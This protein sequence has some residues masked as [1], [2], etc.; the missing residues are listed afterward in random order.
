L[1]VATAR[2]VGPGGSETY[3]LT[4]AEHLARLGHD[5][6][7]YAR[8]VGEPVAGWAH[9]RALSITAEESELPESIDAVIIG[10]YPALALRMADRYPGAA[11]LF[12][13]HSEDD[14]YL[15]P[16]LPG[17]VTA[18]VALSDRQ[19]ERAAACVGAGEVVRLRQPVDLRVFGSRR[20]SAERPVRVLLLGHY[21]SSA[22]GR[23]A[24]IRDAWADAGLEW[25][26]IGG[27]TA[28]LSVAE[29]MADV[30]IVVGYGRA[31]L[32]GMACGRAVYVHDHSG[33]EGWVTA[34]SYPTLE[35][36]GFAVSSHRTGHD[37]RAMRED[38]RAYSPELGQ[39]GHE[40]ARA[41]HDARI[42]AARLVALIERLRPPATP[43]PAPVDGSVARAL[44]M[45]AEAHMRAE[46]LADQSR[47][48]V[49][50]WIQA[51]AVLRDAMAEERANWAAERAVL[52]SLA[53]EADARLAAFKATRRYRLMAAVMRP[54]DRRRG[55]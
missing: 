6:V 12:V 26:E 44:I 13:P 53:G 21:H 22:N 17:A 35:A 40:L 8:A 48:E 45:L 49:K 42:H 24:A 38:L 47:Q 16:P 31:A 11:R 10:V 54:L 28:T 32:E 3:A 30:D 2:L 25:L 4:V 41:H 43:S 29:A 37:T 15:P 34:E 19:A 27:Q 20:R 50:L 36:G 18:T 51:N 1:I 55:R 52:V 39:V 14:R 23:G 9:A 7:L 33:T 46:G 5:V